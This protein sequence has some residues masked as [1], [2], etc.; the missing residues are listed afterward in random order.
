LI[1]TGCRSTTITTI[2]TTTPQPGNTT[3][4]VAPY[5]GKPGVKIPVTVNPCIDDPEGKIRIDN[6]TMISGTLDGK[7]PYSPLHG[8]FKAGDPCFL[9]SGIITNDYQEG[10]WVAHHAEGYDVAGNWVAATL[11]MGPIAGVD[12]VYIDVNNSE[13]FVLH[14]NWSDNV[15]SMEIS[16]QR[17]GQMFP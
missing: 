9:V 3:I 5:S 1:I 15:N 8:T 14:L 4:T 12:Q 17:S 13:N 16:F 7:E 10:S 6:I 2:T 11:D